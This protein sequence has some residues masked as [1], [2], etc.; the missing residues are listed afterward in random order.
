MVPELCSDDDATHFDDIP[1][2]DSGEEFFPTP[3]VTCE[4]APLN[5]S[6][7]MIC[8]CF[9]KVSVSLH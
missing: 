3:K 6:H 2:P 5:T 1:E 4:N 7:F 8:L 9:Y